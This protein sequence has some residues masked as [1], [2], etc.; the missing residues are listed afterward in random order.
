MTQPFT[1]ANYTTTSTRTLTSPCGRS[2]QNHTGSGTRQVEKQTR[3]GCN[4]RI[5]R[6]VSCSQWLRPSVHV[7]NAIIG[8]RED[9]L[10]L[11]P[12]ATA[13]ATAGGYNP[14]IHGNYDPNADYAKVDKQ[15]WRE[16]EAASKT[17]NTGLAPQMGVALFPPDAEAGRYA[18]IVATNRFSGGVQSDGVGPERH[19]DA[20]KSHRQMNAY[21]DVDAAANA[22]DGR[23]LKEERKA[24]KLTKDQVKAYN[25]AR[26]EKKQKKRL[27]FYKS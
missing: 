17:W 26:H 23:S 5:K 2:L 11:D 16:E 25:Q 3:S 24:Q 22:H 4:F 1:K 6:R 18:S 14:K 20:A 19:S 12:K 9:V 10:K 15:K 13:A 21:F 27:A 7:N 8:T